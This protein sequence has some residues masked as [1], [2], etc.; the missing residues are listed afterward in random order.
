MHEFLPNNDNPYYHTHQ[1]D[2]FVCDIPRAAFDQDIL[3]SFG[4]FMTIC[5]IRKEDRIKAVI[6]AYKQ[7]KKAHQI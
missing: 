1:V 6:H 5:R 3:Y 4:A 2:W 7:G